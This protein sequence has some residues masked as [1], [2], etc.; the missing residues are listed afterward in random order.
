MD[1]RAGSTDPALAAQTNNM[2]DETS[3]LVIDFMGSKSEWSFSSKSLV[4]VAPSGTYKAL[5]EVQSHSFNP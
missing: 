3:E 5:G 2:P 4:K 1:E